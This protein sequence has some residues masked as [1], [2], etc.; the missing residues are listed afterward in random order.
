MRLETL[1]RELEWKILCQNCLNEELEEAIL[2]EIRV[3]KGIN[4]NQ[5]TKTL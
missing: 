4:A 2:A 1:L 5:D 3:A